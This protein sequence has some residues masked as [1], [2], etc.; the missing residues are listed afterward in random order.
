AGR[1]D[2][3]AVDHGAV[4]ADVGAPALGVAVHASVKP[5]TPWSPRHTQVWSM[6]TLSLL[7]SSAVLVRPMC[8]PPTRKYT[9]DRV[10]GLVG[11][12]ALW[13]CSRPTRSRTG[14]STLPASIVTPA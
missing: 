5:S 11:L 8:G 14:D 13:P 9:S 2:V 4:A 7:T 12:L 1:G 10:V 3:V 6:S